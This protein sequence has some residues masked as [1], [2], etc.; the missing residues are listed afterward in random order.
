MMRSFLT[1]GLDFSSFRVGNLAEAFCA[2]QSLKLS[3]DL[4]R[5]G[6]D[7]EDFLLFGP[8]FVRFLN[9][10]LPDALS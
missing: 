2:S 6:I 8:N 7:F 10:S 1:F 9:L 5:R 4:D 3:H